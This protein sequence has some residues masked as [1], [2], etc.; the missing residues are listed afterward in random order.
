MGFGGNPLG[1][2]PDDTLVRASNRIPD[3]KRI[4]SSEQLKELGERLDAIDREFRVLYGVTRS[5]RFSM[6]I[7]FK[8]TAS[9]KLAIKQARPWVYSR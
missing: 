2:L 6:E 4:L 3:G 8:I 5:A 1:D 9:G 7:E